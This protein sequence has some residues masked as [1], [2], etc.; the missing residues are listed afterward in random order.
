MTTTFLF[1][2][3]AGSG[4]VDIRLPRDWV[5]A[6][7]ATLGSWVLAADAVSLEWPHSRAAEKAVREMLPVA[8]GVLYDA[9]ERLRIITPRASLH[10]V[11]SLLRTLDPPQAPDL[12]AWYELGLYQLVVTDELGFALEPT[13]K[14]RYT[15]MLPA[16]PYDEN[17]CATLDDGSQCKLTLM[18]PDDPAPGRRAVLAICDEDGHSRERMAYLTCKRD[19]VHITYMI[20]PESVVAVRDI[21]VTPI[22]ADGA[23]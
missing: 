7:A 22:R 15:A 17:G 6:D 3:Y 19:D 8:G 14:W 5:F 9:R 18:R 16:A 2:P 1:K 10:D 21:D 23:I 4:I 20:H 12:R 11:W 13:P